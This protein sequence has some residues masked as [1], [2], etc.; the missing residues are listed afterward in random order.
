MSAFEVSTAL[1]RATAGQLR[2]AIAL[3]R[4]VHDGG[5]RARV[6][7]AGAGDV[8]AQEA[9]ESFLDRWAYGMGLIAHDAEAL[10]QAL[11]HAADA[12]DAVDASIA[13]GCG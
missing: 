6:L 3:G 7:A 5:R 13:G 9:V 10:E 8:T 4:H 1:L 11:V 2:T 12:Y